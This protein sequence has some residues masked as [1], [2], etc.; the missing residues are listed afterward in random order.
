MILK[1][2]GSNSTDTLESDL[3]SQGLDLSVIEPWRLEELQAET[4]DFELWEEHVPV[5]ELFMRCIRQWR[6]AGEAFL[7]IDYTVLAWVSKLSG[8]EPTL[9]LLDDFQIME[10]KAVDILNEQKPHKKKKGGK[11]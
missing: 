10:A 3:A 9:Q 7:G 1:K 2:K 11:R 6:T 5:V 4:E 8:I